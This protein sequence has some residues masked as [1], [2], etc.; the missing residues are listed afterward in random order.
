MFSIIYFLMWIRDSTNYIV[1]EE[2]NIRTLPPNFFLDELPDSLTT[3]FYYTS[4]TPITKINDSIVLIYSKLKALNIKR[5]IAIDKI[6][7]LEETYHKT[8]TLLDTYFKNV[9]TDIEK[10]TIIF[11]RSIDSLNNIL[12][13][14][15]QN[16]YVLRANIEYEIARNKHEISKVTE[17][18]YNLPIVFYYDTSLYRSIIYKVDS[19]NKLKS[20]LSSID[21]SM[22]YYKGNLANLSL[23]FH[24]ERLLYLSYLDFLYFSALTAVNSGFGDIA[25]NS[26]PVRMI[27]FCQIIFSIILF[28]YIIDLI[29]RSFKTRNA[30]N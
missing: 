4:R 2:Y 28:A 12:S 10:N 7:V 24:K 15:N 25:P 3:L 30:T 26:T 29:L 21:Q 17:H 16:D 19:V 9:N 1:H 13:R 20:Q 23:R 22:M 11:Q 27:I 6:K 5:K 14:L 18:I 8:D